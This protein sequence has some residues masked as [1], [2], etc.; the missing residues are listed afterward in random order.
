MEP[1]RNT[2]K[3]TLVGAA[4]LAT[5]APAQAEASEPTEDGAVLRFSEDVRPVPRRNALTVEV[6][7]EAEAS[8]RNWNVTVATAEAG[9]VLCRT[10]LPREAGADYY[11]FTLQ[12]QPTAS[13]QHLLLL[14]ARVNSAD[15]PL[16]PPHYQI[17]FGLTPHAGAS[18]W[19]C[20]VVARGERTELDGGPLFR[21]EDHEGESRLTRRDVVDTI[22]FCGLQSDEVPEYDLYDPGTGRFEPATEVQVLTGEALELEATL[23]EEEIPLP[24]TRNFFSWVAASSDVRGAPAGAAP[25]RPLELGAFNLRRAWIE[26]SSDGGSGEFVTASVNDIVPVTGLRIAPGHG[27]SVDHYGNYALPTQVLIGLS[28]GERF[29]VDLPEVSFEEIQRTGG[30]LIELPEPVTTRCLSVMILDA[31]PGALIRS[32]NTENQRLGRS[33]TISEITPY[34]A[35]DHPEA[36]QTARN[37]IDLILSKDRPDERDRVSALGAEIPEHLSTA[38]DELL[39]EGD[40]DRNART[41]P[42]LGR[43]D[44]EL[45][46]PI[47]TEHFLRID[48]AEVDYRRTKRAI[49]GHGETAAPALLEVLGELDMEE[50]KYVDVVRLLGR[51]G[52]PLDLQPLLRELGEGPE[53]LRRERI[54]AIAA[55]GTPM[56]VPVLS[57]VAD[58]PEESPTSL[59]GLTTLV[60]IGQRHFYH[61]ATDAD[62]TEM[63]LERAKTGTPRAF[64]R[65]AI[66]A[67]GYLLTDGGTAVLIE[68]LSDDPDPLIRSFA[69]GALRLHL[70]SAPRQALEEAL[71]DASPDVRIAAI[72]SLARRDDAPDATP[73]VIAFLEAE[74]W[75]RAIHHA[76]LLLAA[77]PHDEAAVALADLVERDPTTREAATAM[78][79]LRREKRALPLPRIT[80]YLDDDA[81]PH[82]LLRQL[83]DM[84]AFVDDPMADQTLIA[85]A[86]E[87][88]EG[89]RHRPPEA[90]QDLSHRALVGL[91]LRGSTRATD[92]LLSV[93]FDSNREV[94]TRSRALR[95]LGFVSNEEIADTLQNRASELPRE[96]RTPLRQTINQIRSRLAIEDADR[97]IQLLREALEEAD[98]AD[99]LYDSN[100]PVD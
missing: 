65:R 1:L 93:A 55:G 45:S 41:L 64:R 16:D 12:D 4:L 95:G 57:A 33:V 28:D 8:R 52:R 62:G 88:Y 54:R 100:D 38:I 56:V 43:L 46:L 87:S 48:P 85:V 70:G 40:A 86:A 67:L 10:T 9:A 79:A 47:L 74:R 13:A 60:F 77:S 98:E 81:V 49:A 6:S 25:P 51:V 89:L 84:L 14:D 97:E 75:P 80:A 18:G 82:A 22:R 59:D 44:P 29:L 26:G 76:A 73:V 58:A 34:S 32:R 39:R 3:A 63:L 30:Y 66:E 94:S 7:R 50:R 36:E 2:F 72:R 68:L 19:R 83:V 92:F 23:P 5:V 53:F 96:L 17:V 37:L 15:G 21:F 20:Q 69:A 78:R 99:D 35:A 91:G 42:L 61:E 31:R 24:H 90:I 11:D 71:Q 27:A